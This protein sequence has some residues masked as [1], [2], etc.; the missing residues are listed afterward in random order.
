MPTLPAT[1]VCSSSSRSRRDPCPNS[2]HPGNQSAL[3]GH[4]VTERRLLVGTADVHPVVVRNGVVLYAPGET[5]LG[6]MTRSASR[7]RRRALT[8]ALSGLLD[9]WLHRW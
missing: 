9:P 2:G 1:L 5:N 8:R 3:V 6:R 7:A 4:L